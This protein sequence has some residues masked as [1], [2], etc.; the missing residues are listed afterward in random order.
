ML[1]FVFTVS[2]RRLRHCKRPVEGTTTP[3]Y[4]N[5]DIPPELV[6]EHRTGSRMERGGDGGG[7]R[8]SVCDSVCH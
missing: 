2:A 7:V 4:L 3:R 6:Q 5:T 1:C 8:D